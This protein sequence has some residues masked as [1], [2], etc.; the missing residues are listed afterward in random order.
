MPNI[1]WELRYGIM[2]PFIVHIWPQGQGSIMRLVRLIDYRTIGGCQSQLSIGNLKNFPIR[3]SI[4]FIKA[5]SDTIIDNFF[6]AIYRRLSMLSMRV[7][8]EI[9][10]LSIY[11]QQFS[12][13][14]RLYLIEYVFTR[15]VCHRNLHCTVQYCIT[16][17]VLCYNCTVQQY[18]L[19]YTECSMV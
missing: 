4:A 15:T 17:S 12:N 13:I 16:V 8:Q 11:R 18:Q 1:L 7:P 19:Y 5:F 9:S 10:V 14:S 3:L 6:S 2:L